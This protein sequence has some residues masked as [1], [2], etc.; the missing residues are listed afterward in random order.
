MNPTPPPPTPAEDPRWLR[1]FAPIWIGQVFS[2]FGSGLVHFSLIWWLTQT[3][4]SAVVLATASLVGF[5]PQVVLGPFAG[6]LVDRWNRRRVMMLS[7]SGI[8][9]ATLGLVILFALGLAQPWHVYLILFL[10]SLGGAFHWPALQASTTLLVPERHLA[11]VA[12]A[13][14]ASMA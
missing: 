7:D 14:Q 3:T 1:R 2:L 12:G 10:R 11:R 13:N 9:L 8:A 5:L 6:A 4:G